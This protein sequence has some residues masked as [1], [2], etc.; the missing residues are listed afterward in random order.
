MSRA[1]FAAL[2][3]LTALVV[4]LGAFAAG[5]TLFDDGE[6]D[7]PPRGG[8]TVTSLV[9]ADEATP[10]TPSTST[11]ATSEPGVGLATPAWV[12]VVASETS[13]AAARSK[14]EPV[15]AAG[16]PVG[17]LRSDDYGSLKPG[18]WVAYAGPYPDRDAAD[19]AV[20]ELAADGFAGAYSRCVG[21]RE[22]CRGGDD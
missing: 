7:A 9:P 5:L 10:S 11:P 8:G 3:I 14:S 15:G 16:H 18:L 17:V 2:V 22:E 1:R 4:G 21:S 13:E 12:A 19:A 20:D 6:P